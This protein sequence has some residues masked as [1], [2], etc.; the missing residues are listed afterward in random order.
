MAGA[1]MFTYPGGAEGMEPVSAGM[2]RVNAGRGVAASG[3]TGRNSKGDVP[4]VS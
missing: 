1:G 4:H 3:V 2:R